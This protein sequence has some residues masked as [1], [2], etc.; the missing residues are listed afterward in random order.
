MLQLHTPQQPQVQFFF[1]SISMSIMIHSCL[2]NLHPLSTPELAGSVLSATSSNVLD[3]EHY[4]RECMC[5]NYSFASYD[6]VR[7]FGVRK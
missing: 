6:C 3:Q 1:V 7:E 5:L 2:G 4:E